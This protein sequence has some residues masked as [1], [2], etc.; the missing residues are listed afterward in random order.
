MWKRCRSLHAGRRRARAPPSS[1]WRRCGARPRGSRPAPRRRAAGPSLRLAAVGRVGHLVQRGVHEHADQLEPPVQL[2]AD[3]PRAVSSAQR[4][5]AARPEDHAERPGARGPRPGGRPPG[6]SPH[7]SSRGSRPQCSQGASG[8]TA[9]ALPR[10]AAASGAGLVERL[11]RALGQLHLVG[12]LVVA[13]VV[14]DLDRCRPACLPAIAATTSSAPVTGLPSTATITSPPP[15][16]RR[17]GPPACRPAFVG[18]AAV[19]R[20]RS[21]ARRSSTGRSSCVAQLRGHVAHLHAQVG[22]L[23][24]L[25]RAQLRQQLLR[26][27]DRA[28]RS[29]CP[30]SPGRRRWRSGELMPITAP[31]ASS[32]G[33]PELPGL[34]EASV[35]ITSLIGKPLGAST[36]RCERRHDARWSPC[37]AGRT[38][39]RSRRPGR[40]PGPSPSRPAAAR[41][42]PR[43]VG[44]IFS[45]ATSLSS[46]TP[47]TS[48]SI[49]SPP[50]SKLTVTFDA[51]STTWALVTIVPSPSTTKPEPVAVPCCCWPKTSCAAA[52]AL[53]LDVH[54]AAALLAVD[55]LHRLARRR[56][57]PG[58]WP[59]ARSAP[60]APRVVVSPVSITSVAIRIGADHQH[61]QPA[62]HAG[63]QVGDG[64]T[65]LRGRRHGVHDSVCRPPT[66]EPH[67]SPRSD[68]ARAARRDRDQPDAGGRAARSRAVRSR[69]SARRSRRLGA[70][71]RAR[72][73]AVRA[74]ARPRSAPPPG[75]AARPSRRS[76]PSSVVAAGTS[77]SSRSSARRSSASW[78]SASSRGVQPARAAATRRQPTSA[79]AAEQ[80][81]R[82]Q[83]PRR[84]AAVRAAARR[85]APRSASRSGAAAPA[86]GAV[87]RPAGGA[88]SACR[89]AACASAGAA[90][91]VG[92]NVHPADA[93]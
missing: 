63:D 75:P 59:A 29:R 81:Q 54:H 82:Q 44:S 73:V 48:A 66:L 17:P 21:R 16:C 55:L 68:R 42:G 8:A 72:V 35:W 23:D 90:A 85:A 14:L 2:G 32:S 88:A 74:Q 86:R 56:S 45:T 43:L 58:R 26:G 47:L 1:P 77:Q 91:G 9:A 38:G 52:D 53:G 33:P 18:R 12:P 30:P 61:D 84:R 36:W 28:P 79:G 62:E 67:K 7:R 20:P 60:A 71:G 87:D 57:R 15:T 64:G 80:Q 31:W 24:V 11:L 89:S 65:L 3:L 37:A 69:R 39:C 27:V 13:A 78:A 6:R 76:R 22:A 5:R 41:A 83:Q 34:I 46:S 25:A 10:A 19:R 70:A 50:S 40:R 51:P 93:R 4:A 49:A 92:S